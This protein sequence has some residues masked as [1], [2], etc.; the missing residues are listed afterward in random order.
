MEDD[1]AEAQRNRERGALNGMGGT[2]GG[3]WRVPLMVEGRGEKKA[4]EVFLALVSLHQ[5][6]KQ[7]RRIRRT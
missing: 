1:H 7:G 4:G 5:Q 2:R 3:E 6:A